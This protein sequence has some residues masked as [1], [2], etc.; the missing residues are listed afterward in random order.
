MQKN[1]IKKKI[2]KDIKSRLWCF[3]FAYFSYA[4]IKAPRCSFFAFLSHS[5]TLAARMGVCVSATVP[6]ASSSSCVL[7][8]H[9]PHPSRHHYHHHPSFLSATFS[10]FLVLFLLFLQLPFSRPNAL[11][12]CCCCFLSA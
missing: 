11:A 12:F 3:V 5:A 7:S 9:P 1:K 10:R 2:V 4:V 6:A 8:S